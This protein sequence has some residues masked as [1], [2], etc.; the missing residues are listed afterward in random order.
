MIWKKLGVFVLA[1]VLVAACAA[2]PYRVIHVAPTT[3][4]D[5]VYSCSLGLASSLQS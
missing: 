1:G 5:A 3:T 4:A 2:Q